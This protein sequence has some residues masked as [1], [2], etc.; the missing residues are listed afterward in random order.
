MKNKFS[1]LL[2]LCWLGSSLI[3]SGCSKSSQADSGTTLRVDIGSE[4]PTFDP[5]L[6]EDGSTYRVIN[7]LYAGLIDFDQENQ[8]ISGLAD[9]WQISSDGKTYT[10]HLRSNL[11]FSDGSPLKASDFVYA[12]QRLV[13]PQTGSAYSF[14]LKDV[15]NGAKIIAGKLP[16]TALG[17]KALDAQTIV[18]KLSHPTNAFLAYLT[19]PNVD[20][21][22]QAA[23]EK[24]GAKWT[25]PQNI[26]TS[27]AYVLREHVLNGYILA[28]KNHNFYA[29]SLVQ[30]DKVKYFP[31]VDSNASLANYKTGALDT[32]WQ[33]VPIDQY[34]QL[35]QQFPEELRTF[36][37][38]RIDY[39]NINHQLGKYAN[40]LK[41]RQALTLA[42]NRQD[43]VNYVLNAGQIP[44]Y[45]VVTPTIENGKYADLHYSWS[46]WPRT[47]QL[48]L[49]Q[50]LY[51][52]AGYGPTKPLVI[53][54]KYQ[55]ND[56]N[57]KVMLAIMA[58]WQDALGVKVNLVNE[59]LKVLTPDLKSGN[60]EIAQGR[61]GADYNSITTYTPLFICNNGNN[62][63]HYCNSKY[64]ALIVKAE[65]T[66]D[67]RQQ[68]Q[69]YKQA[70]QIVLDDYAIIPLFE[71][72]HQRLVSPRVNGYHIASNYLDNV[73]SKWLSLTP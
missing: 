34:Q 69:L 29:E 9:K 50:Q 60:Y 12:W 10:F 57:K 35:K 22:S 45:S 40:N 43:L 20:V 4:I 53:N 8:P 6:A 63:A 27:G 66:A 38:E 36:K 73:Q 30:I 62:R 37:W 39:L 54:L 2:G 31:Y 16:A 42:I 44:L 68:E 41:L 58:M 19:M 32:S 18:V 64:D 17:I 65:A 1:R 13:D 52:E 25:E 14:L 24:F 21:V 47:K 71:P 33:N 23:V 7:D 67:P 72:T 11:K 70:L 5:A 56:L 15:V 49:A 46:S 55:T 51:R 61:W 59:E 26:V 3:V 28:S 48:A